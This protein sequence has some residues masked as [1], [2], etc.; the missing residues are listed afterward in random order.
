MAELRKWFTK[1][2]ERLGF[3]GL[4]GVYNYVFSLPDNE[5]LEY[6]SSLLGSE[7]HI[8]EFSSTFVRKRASAS[9][10]ASSCTASASASEDTALS[11]WDDV[12]ASN[13]PPKKSKRGKGRAR[14]ALNKNPNQRQNQPS[15]FASKVAPKPRPISDQSKAIQS[16]A[17]EQARAKIRD[18]R[19]TQR[20]V[21]CM[22]CGKVERQIR[23]D[24]ACSF[25]NSPIFPIW[26]GK[27]SN[28]SQ[29]NGSSSVSSSRRPVRSQE[30]NLLPIVL[31][32]YCYPATRFRA[33]EGSVA[34]P[35]K[36]LNGKSVDTEPGDIE[37][38]D[39]GSEGLSTRYYKNPLIDREQLDR[40]CASHIT[41]L[42]SLAKKSPQGSIPVHFDGRLVIDDISPSVRMSK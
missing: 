24:G 10:Q 32:R 26:D 27:N 30:G 28:M 17:V 35:A 19:K 41:E 21:N 13:A 37:S 34:P 20:V 2:I 40:C 18:Y 15:S 4:E 11:F 12:S 38:A 14:G 22:R 33:E 7:P 42:T 23:E 1:E 39:G 8:Q 3:A 29:Q 6:L 36:F 9:T 16:A 31:G 5:A 25:C